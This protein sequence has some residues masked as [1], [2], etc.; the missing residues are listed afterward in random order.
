MIAYELLMTR[1]SLGHDLMM[2][3]HYGYLFIIRGPNHTRSRANHKNHK[4]ILRG[5][6]FS[7][8]F[9][10]IVLHLIFGVKIN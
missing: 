1:R 5:V 4:S 2:A 9:A 8:H 3:I 7:F 10:A 6:H